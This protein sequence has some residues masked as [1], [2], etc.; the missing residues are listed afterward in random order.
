MSVFDPS[1]ATAD[2]GDT[3][4]FN[5]TQGN[6]T[7]IQSNFTSPCIAVHDVNRT[8]PIYGFNSG[9]HDTKNG[10]APSTY[11]VLV[12]DNSTMWFF[13]ATTCGDGGIGGINLDSSSEQTLDGARNNAIRFNG[14][15]T[16]TTKSFHA[17]GTRST[18]ASTTGR[19]V[20]SSGAERTVVLGIVLTIPLVI[21]AVIL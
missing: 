1:E 11:G 4:I 17:T 14:T 6:H 13:D 18:T 19:T 5:F 15:N 16:T 9:V 20:A 2:I 7:A 8:L 10:T 21:A 3:I 12:T